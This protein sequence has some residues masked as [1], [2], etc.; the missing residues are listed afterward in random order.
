MTRLQDGE[1]ELIKFSEHPGVN[2]WE[3][4]VDPAAPGADACVYVRADAT[5]YIDVIHNGTV[6]DASVYIDSLQKA[7]K[8]AKA[9][10]PLAKVTINRG[11]TAPI[12]YLNRQR[13]GRNDPCP[14]GCG[15]KRKHHRDAS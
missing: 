4:G 7:A 5:S 1:Q 14:C 11:V 8:A 6:G 2:M 9:Y 12:E 10:K 3:M 15:R 13:V